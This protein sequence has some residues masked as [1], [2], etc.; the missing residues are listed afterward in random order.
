VLYQADTFG[1]SPD[2]AVADGP[3]GKI[4]VRSRDGDVLLINRDGSQRTLLM[5][6]ART[7]ISM[8]TCA[9]R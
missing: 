1:E 7:Y 6:E 5:P 3:A 9:D 8:S 4:L 2:S